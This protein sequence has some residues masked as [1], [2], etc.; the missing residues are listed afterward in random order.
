MTPTAV[1]EQDHVVQPL[2][3]PEKMPKQTLRVPAWED[4]FPIAV[5]VFT[6]ETDISDHEK[7]VIIISGAT[8]CW[9]HYYAAFATY[10]LVK[11]HANWYRWLTN[12][13]VAAVTWDYRY[14][15]SQ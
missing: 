13:G 10:C 6:P 11:I 5:T 8:G 9:Q 1:K 15:V 4:A 3:I 14:T 7:V 2:K 12:H